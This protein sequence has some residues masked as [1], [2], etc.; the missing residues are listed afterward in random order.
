MAIAGIVPSLYSPGGY[1]PR[2]NAAPVPMS[3]VG[4]APARNPPPRERVLEGE[5]LE[6]FAVVDAAIETL[7][8]HAYIEGSVEHRAGGIFRQVHSGQQAVAAYLNITSV[9]SLLDDMPARVDF[10]V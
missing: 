8:S 3:P 10:F 5:L 4:P 2:S 6:P 7:F 1:P 9:Q